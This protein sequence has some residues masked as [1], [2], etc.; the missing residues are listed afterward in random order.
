MSQTL[1][2]SFPSFLLTTPWVLTFG[3]ELEEVK[4]SPYKMG[5]PFRQKLHT[6]VHTFTLAGSFFLLE[7]QHAAHAH[8]VARYPL[9]WLV[10]SGWM[11]EKECSTNR[12]PRSFFFFKWSPNC[13]LW[14]LILTDMWNKSNRLSN[15]LYSVPGYTVQQET[16]NSFYCSAS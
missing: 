12:L 14:P 9:V 16:Y 15:V 11:W 10:H 5:H 1:V 8:Y 6:L 3:H 7:I 4:I 2:Q 13:F